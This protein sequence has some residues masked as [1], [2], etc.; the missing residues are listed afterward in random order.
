M[1]EIA[2]LNKVICMNR[3][4]LALVLISACPISS[5]AGPIGTGTG[6]I[7]SGGGSGG[8]G[9]NPCRAGYS[10]M[11]V[12]TATI[13]VDY[14]FQQKNVCEA[15]SGS[16]QEIINYIKL[17]LEGLANDLVNEACPRAYYR[18]GTVETN[19]F[20]TFG[21]CAEM[22][23]LVNGE[24]Q[25]TYVTKANG[26]ITALICCENVKPEICEVNEIG[27]E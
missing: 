18:K 1:S 2:P 26:R 10:Y 16:K 27:V 13:K 21:V 11:E 25:T 17:K 7:G 8:G 12:P 3:F 20:S 15:K 14:S 19:N 9:S 24:Y 23:S 5:M 4:V 22:N 6:G